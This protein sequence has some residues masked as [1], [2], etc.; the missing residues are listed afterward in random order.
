MLGFDWK[1]RTENGGNMFLDSDLEELQQQAVEL[2]KP[3]SIPYA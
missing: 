1:D 2:V 3:R